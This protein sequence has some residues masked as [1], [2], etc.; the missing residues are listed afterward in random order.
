MCGYEF[1][2]NFDDDCVNRFINND[3]DDDDDDK[4]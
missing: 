1:K 4:R 2:V 3:D